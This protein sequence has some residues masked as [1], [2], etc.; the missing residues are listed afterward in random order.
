MQTVVYKCPLYHLLFCPW[1]IQ[2]ILLLNYCR[3]TIILLLFSSRTSEEVY[4][5]LY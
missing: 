3:I 1:Y 2:C 5:I 4:M